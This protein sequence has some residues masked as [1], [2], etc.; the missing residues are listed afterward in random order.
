M[1]RGDHLRNERPRRT[2]HPGSPGRTRHPGGGGRRLLPDSGEPETE[3]PAGP[4]GNQPDAGEPPLPAPLPGDPGHRRQHRHQSG[5]L[6]HE[7]Q[8]QD[9]G[10][11]GHPK[12][13]H[14][15]DPSPA[16]REHDPGN[17]PR[18]LPVRAV[19]E[20]DLGP[21]PVQFPT[22]RRRPGGLHQRLH[23]PRLPRLPG[24]SP[25]GRGD[26]HHV[27]PP[28]RRGHRRHRRLQGGHPDAGRDRLPARGRHE[29]GRLRTDRGHL[30]HQP[31]GHGSLQ[32]PDQGI[33][34]HRPRRGRA[35]RLRSGQRQR[36]AGGDSCERGRVRS[37]SLQHPQDLLHAPRLHGTRYRRR[38]GDRRVEAV[39]SPAPGRVRRRTLLLGLPGRS[40]KH[41]PGP[42]VSGQRPGRRQG[43]R[44]GHAARRRRVAGS[45]R[46]L[47]AQQ[48]LHVEEA[49]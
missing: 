38:R 9:S 19:P 6:Y 24:R 28:L 32:P 40:G 30:H 48:Q 16:G 44:L 2:G 20:G 41:R 27:L 36:V 4:A 21:G 3:K 18:L 35:L 12:P 31:G 39:S 43:L 47:R 26:H 1:G 42:F 33:R 34:R 13:G 23:G 37:L 29:G 5:D 45:G 11:R 15:R 46:V 25:A 14:G 49:E 17:P 10:A 7:V 8:P 22:G